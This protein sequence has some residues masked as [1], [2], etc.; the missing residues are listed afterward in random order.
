MIGRG[1]QVRCRDGRGGC[2]SRGR[3]RGS[4]HYTP[5]SNKNKGLCSAL[6]QNI[7]DY[8][9][10]GEKDQ[11]RTT[12][13]NIVHHVEIVYG[14]DISNGMQNKTKFSIP[15]PEYTKDI[16]SKCKH[17]VKLINLHSAR[18]S[19]AMEAKRV[20]MTRA[21]EDGNEPESPIKMAML[22]N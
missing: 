3:G 20:V 11:M 22:E 16:H 9:Q 18:I 15:K 19:E 8:D 10:K 7:F 1:V 21:V 2:G 5:T 6:G 12:W 13:Q 17:R 14:H 4:G